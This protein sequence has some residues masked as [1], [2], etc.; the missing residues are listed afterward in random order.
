MD[1]L[2]KQR[3][4]C[5]YCIITLA[6]LI[7][8]S[9]TDSPI[10]PKI[11]ITVRMVI[12]NQL[13]ARSA[14][15]MHV[16][17]LGV[18]N[19]LF[20]LEGVILE[21]Q[22]T[23]GHFVA[24]SD[25]VVTVGL[26]LA[27]RKRDASGAVRRRQ[28][29]GAGAVAVCGGGAVRLAVLVI[30]AVERRLLRQVG[31][32][33]LDRIVQVASHGCRLR[34][35]HLRHERPVVSLCGVADQRHAHQAGHKSHSHHITSTCDLRHSHARKVVTG[36]CTIAPAATICRAQSN[37]LQRAVGV[38]GRW[39]LMSSGMVGTFLFIRHILI[40]GKLI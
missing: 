17:W 25:G 27:A 28:R 20:K 2:I 38:G 10:I 23:V 32:H 21:L 37:T 3:R 6:I 15:V 1:P 39:S 13:A 24:S 30:V 12:D 11:Y 29:A 31:D 19:T 7:T 22:E 4:V 16:G 34:V 26:H 5:I 35:A 36:I 14:N 40:F 18:I 33:R 8:H 9:T